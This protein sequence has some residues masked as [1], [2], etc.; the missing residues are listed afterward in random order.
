MDYIYPG[1]IVRIKTIDELCEE[2]DLDPDEDLERQPDIGGYTISH[3]MQIWLGGTYKVHDYDSSDGS[4]YLDDTDYWWPKEVVELVS[5]PGEFFG[6]KVGD[7]VEFRQYDHM[8]ADGSID[9][10]A[11]VRGMEHLCGKHCTIT[12]LR[13]ISS[14][15]A[16]VEVSGL[17]EVDSAYCF[18]T[19]MFE[20]V[21]D[22]PEIEEDDWSVIL[23]S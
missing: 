12:K 14:Y 7:V 2:F 23:V 22:I 13:P 15:K 1:Q 18:D 6:F 16:A 9:K 11:F 4:V 19:I 8:V 3:G 20:H 17:N 10:S 5:E 21:E